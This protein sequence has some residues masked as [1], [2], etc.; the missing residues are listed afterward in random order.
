LKPTTVLVA[1]YVGNDLSEAYRSAHHY[2][3]GQEFASTD[4][5]TVA[6][7]SES[8]RAN[9]FAEANDRL[10]ADRPAES[11][12]NVI[13]RWLSDHSLAYGL[14]RGLYTSAANRPAAALGEFA[15]GQW[16]EDSAAQPGR[17]VFDADTRLRTV[18]VNPGDHSMAMNLDDPRIQEGERVTEAVLR[19]VRTRLEAKDIRFAVAII[20]TK[21]TAYAELMTRQKD[22]TPRYFDLLA[23]ERRLTQRLEAFLDRESIAFVNT[24]AVLRGVL[25]EGQRP[26]P[27]SDNTHPNATGYAAIAKALASVV[28]PRGH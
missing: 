6:Q 22:V 20:P 9:P 25:A 12:V 17:I 13:R 24:T 21:A 18:F 5:S 14:L 7:L 26:Y 2:G 16:F 10:F 8:E 11:G 23:K 15:D 4:A 19:S 3:R 28:A 1:V 27:S